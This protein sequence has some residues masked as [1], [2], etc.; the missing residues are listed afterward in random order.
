MANNGGLLCCDHERLR[1][2]VSIKKKYHNRTATC[3]LRNYHELFGVP[4]QP[5][6]FHCGIH[7]DSMTA[8][9]DQTISVARR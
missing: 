1:G 4:Y 8:F 6:A 7:L 9:F 5:L 2:Q 3:E